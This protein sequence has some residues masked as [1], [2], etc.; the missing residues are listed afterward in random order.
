MGEK[1]RNIICEPQDPLADLKRE[2][3]ELINL[4]IVTCNN[5]PRVDFPTTLPSLPSINPSQAVIDFLKDILALVQGINVEQMKMQLIDWLV[6]QLR[7]LEKSISLNI[8]LGLKECFACQINPTIPEW[9]FLTNPNNGSPGEGFNIELNKIDLTCL[10]NVNPNSEE[11]K[12]LYDGNSTNDLNRFLWDVIQANGTPLLWKDPITNKDIAYFTYYEDNNAF[13]E[14]NNSTGPQNIEGREMVFN[15]KIAD[16]FHNKSLITFINDYINSLSP[17][18]DA[19]KVVPNTIEFI[20][21]TLTNQLKL[22]EECV[23]Q[24]V[25]LE[26]AIVDYINIGINDADVEIDNDFYSFTPEQLVSIKSK[27][28][29][30]MGGYKTFEKCCKKQVGKIPFNDLTKFNEEISTTSTLNERLNV[31]SK[32]LSGLEKSS[33]SFVDPTDRNSA[34]NEFWSNFITALQVSLTKMVLSPKNLML[35]QTMNFLVNRE[36]TK[37]TIWGILQSFKCI[38]RVIL[39]DLIN[40]LIYEFLLPLIISALKDI[41]LCYIIKK[42]KEKQIYYLHQM[43]SLLPGQI[44]GKIDKINQVLGKASQITEIAQ[45]FTNQINLNSLNNINIKGMKT[46]KFCD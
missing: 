16:N 42:L 24:I 44:Q 43:L 13:V 5:L 23:T 11:G 46:G 35:F 3:L 9:L 1:L 10:F 7:P 45:G 31:Y 15:M 6:E 41:I 22:P 20:Y 28:K 21:G 38:I 2:I 27:V 8:K 30:K 14:T 19:D 4:R 25:E 32:S 18:F 12:L 33:S 34:N 37:D 39:A 29:D 36:T 17:I 26:E 40:K